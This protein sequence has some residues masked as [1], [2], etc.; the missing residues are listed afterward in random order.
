[1]AMNLTC[2]ACK[3]LIE[4]SMADNIREVEL[5]DWD[6]GTTKKDKKKNRMW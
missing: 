2:L 6:F 5:D 1:M 3:M 4:I